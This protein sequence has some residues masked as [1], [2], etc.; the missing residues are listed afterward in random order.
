M[1]TVSSTENPGQGV[2]DDCYHNDDNP[3]PQPDVRGSSS[4]ARDVL[5][6]HFSELQGGASRLLAARLAQLLSQVDALEENSLRPLTA[7][8]TLIL[9]GVGQADQLLREGEAALRCGLEEDQLRSFNQ[10]ALN[11]QLDS[12]PEVPALVDVACVSAQLDDSVLEVLKERL[13]SHG[14]VSSRPPVRITQLQERPGAMLV[15]WAKYRRST[16]GGAYEEAYVGGDCEVVVV[17]LD[18][19]TEHLFRVSARQ[20]GRSAW[21]PWSV[22]QG[23]STSLAPHEWSPGVDGYI[24]SS[25]RNIAMRC[26]SA[27]SVSAAGQADH[28]D[29]VGVCVERESGRETLQRDQ[30][31]CISTKG[32]VF[33]NGKEMTNRLPALALGSAVTFDTEVVALFPASS[34]DSLSEGGANVKL[35]VAIGCGSREVVFDWLLEAR[36]DGLFFGCCFAHVGWKVLVY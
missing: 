25:R 1:S 31:V 24:L 35:R 4:Q 14:S 30:S 19:Q 8:Q 18:P 17:H 22:P 36:V 11:V 7:C 12:L 26:D 20:D 15:R 6:R 27:P 13:P 29:G 32:A 21:S 10:K 3:R 16:G 28:R 9:Q 23:G 5:R 34:G 33:V 2:P